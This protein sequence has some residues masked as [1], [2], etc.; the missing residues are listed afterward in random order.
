MRLPWGASWSCCDLEPRRFLD[1][2][3]AGMTA[4]PSLLLITNEGRPGG[5]SGQIDGYRIL[6]ST[7][8]LGRVHAVSARQGF[9]TDPTAA[10][11]RVLAAIEAT[12]PDLAM[13]WS[14]RDFPTERRQFEQVRSALGKAEILYWEGD[15]WGRK[16][17]ISRQME[18]WLSASDA[19]FSVGGDPQATLLRR[20]GA[21]R[22]FL[23]LHTYD[24]LAFSEAENYDK[25]DPTSETIMICRNFARLPGF[26]GLPGS[27]AR[28]RLANG[29]RRQ[30]GGSFR[31][32]GG[33]WPRGWAQSELPYGSQAAAV[34][35]A[36]LMVNWDHYPRTSD[37][38]S[39]RLPIALLAG[40]P[41]ITTAH[42]G[43][44]WAPGE[45]LGLFQAKSPTQ[46]VALAVALLAGDPY[47]LVLLGERAHAW[48]KGRMSHREAA[49]YMMS[50]VVDGISPPPA[51]PWENL[52]GPWLG[53]ASH[54]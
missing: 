54:A 35:S 53:T 16:K 24:H 31:L 1:A 6:E 22:V 10:V 4:R 48:V 44:A 40:R 13:V 38:A 19:V 28:W 37:Y 3:G 12:N 27:A 34:R 36:R 32:Y 30:F 51:D 21:Q 47:R 33:G 20:H 29:M 14:P 15:P 11:A 42:P 5:A 18:W 49:R 26:S 41:H 25:V 43:M 9:G 8:E 7:G 46:V 2:L 17:P 23:T 50:Q 52:P 39:D 45:E